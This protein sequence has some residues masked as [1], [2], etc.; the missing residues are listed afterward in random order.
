MVI[1]K[2]GKWSRKATGMFIFERVYR[3]GYKWTPLC[4][5]HFRYIG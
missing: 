5:V 4:V 3:H 2:F 1:I